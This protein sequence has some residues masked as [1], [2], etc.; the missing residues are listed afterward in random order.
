MTTMGSRES[1]RSGIGGSQSRNSCRELYCR[2]SRER[3]VVGGGGRSEQ[4]IFKRV[5][6]TMSARTYTAGTE[7]VG[8]E[9]TVMSERVGILLMFFNL[10]SI[11]ILLFHVLST[12]G[13]DFLLWY[14]R[15]A[16]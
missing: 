10:R 14:I 2:G 11:L 9:T 12:L 1:E 4:A 8:K 3:A 16:D 7:P 15:L 6:G 5:G 13:I